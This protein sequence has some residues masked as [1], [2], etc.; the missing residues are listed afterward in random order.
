VPRAISTPPPLRPI[1]W[2]TG[3]LLLWGHPVAGQECE[4][5]PVSFIF[6]DN[7]SIFD[8]SEDDPRRFR[9][10]YRIANTLHIE[11]RPGFIR[12]Q[13]LFEV[14][15]CPDD[16][17]IEES[18]RIL[19]EFRFLSR[20]DVF[21]VSQ[22]DGTR[23][24]VVDTQDEWTTKLNLN[25]ALDEGLQIE[26]VSLE[27][28]NFLGT[29]NLIGLFFRERRER[30]DYGLLWEGP[31]VIAGA[32]DGAVA[33][34]RTRVGG[35]A[36]QALILPYGSEVGRYAGRQRYSM[37]EDLFA[38]A[39]GR[40]RPE[41]YVTL[42]TEEGFAELTAAFRIG[43]PGNQ[44]QIGGGVSWERLRLPD[45]PGGVEVVEEED[46]GNP[47]PAPPE[48]IEAIAPQAHGRSATRINFVLGQR[49]IRYVRKIGLDPLRGGQ[50]VPMG[51]DFA[52]TLAKSVGAIAPSGTDTTDD[53]YSSMNLLAGFSNEAWTFS[54]TFRLEARQEFEGGVVDP[55]DRRGPGGWRD[56]LSEW[57]AF[58]YFQPET[59]PAHTFVGKIHFQGGWAMT[60]PF[61]LTLGGRYG[62]RGY[63]QNA[64]PGGQRLVLSLEDRV[65]LDWPRTT[66]FDFGLTFFGDLGQMWEGEVPFGVQSGLRGSV[67]A[68]LRLGFPNGTAG[69]FRFDLVAPVKTGFSVSD[70]IL[71]IHMSEILGIDKIFSTEQMIR[72]RRSGVET[73]FIG[74]QRRR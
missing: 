60:T 72:S 32:V 26:G 13:L 62:V 54:S 43:E 57:E 69:V 2:L 28:E 53:I 40:D 30:R 58:L 11:T 9:W 35:F 5:G 19:R 41:G 66:L 7:H 39:V 61:Q 27:E 15:D 50:D 56:I 64:F 71:R 74:V 6:V 45:Y 8:L 49:H 12:D 20:A 59:R 16:F 17:L 73:Q 33:L 25:L 24:V 52:F 46:F 38:Y 31:A 48:A 68:G 3:L 63:S 37:R 36:E 44:T 51:V 21:A 42:P 55:E 29:G 34:G 14:G 10:A 22:P 18:A 70:M 23:H 47:V 1:L 67:G 65:R 4:A